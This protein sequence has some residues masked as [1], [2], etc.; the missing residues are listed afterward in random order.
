ME[1]QIIRAVRDKLIE[2]NERLERL[3][4]PR[5]I[6]TLMKEIT[7][8]LTRYHGIVNKYYLDYYNNIIVTAE[9]KISGA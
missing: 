2:F 7:E 1:E 5:E 8:F 3:Q 6:I 4:H 9:Q